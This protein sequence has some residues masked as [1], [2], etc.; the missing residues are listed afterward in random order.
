M[1]LDT[2]LAERKNHAFAGALVTRGQA[3]GVVSAT[4]SN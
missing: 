3:K 4:L 1:A 2:L